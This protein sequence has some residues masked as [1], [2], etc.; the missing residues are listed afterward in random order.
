M[1]FL[2][3]A[4]NEQHPQRVIFVLLKQMPSVG[5]HRRPRNDKNSVFFWGFSTLKLQNIIFLQIEV[6][7]FR[8]MV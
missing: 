7:P 5:W 3:I 1:R 6:T 8:E 2:A 4:T